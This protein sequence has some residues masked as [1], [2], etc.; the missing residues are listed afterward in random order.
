MGSST[1]LKLILRM[2]TVLT[3]VYN[4]QKLPSFWTLSIVRNSRKMDEVHKPSNSE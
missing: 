1:E 2:Q 3:T 4:A